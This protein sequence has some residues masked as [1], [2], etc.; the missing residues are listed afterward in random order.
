MQLEKENQDSNR[1]KGNQPEDTSKIK[2]G[3]FFRKIIQTENQKE[4]KRVKVL[5]QKKGI[6]PG[7]KGSGGWLLDFI[8]I[9]WNLISKVLN[10]VGPPIQKLIQ[11]TNDL[12]NKLPVDL[13]L[14]MVGLLLV[15]FGGFFSV[16]VA[17]L[18][19]IYCSGWE[20]IKVNF[21][22]LFAES[23]AIW[24]KSKEDDLK[25]EDNDGVADVKQMSITGLF[26]HK[27]GL[28]MANCK[29]PQKVIDMCHGI[30]QCNLNIIATL[31][32]DMAKA[33]TLGHSIGENL[34]KLMSIILVPA[35][36]YLLDKDYHHWIA[37][38]IN[39]VCK[40]ISI[41]ISMLIQRVLS[42]T[43]GAIRGG[44]LFSRRML[45]YL[46][47]IKVVNIDHESTYIDEYVGWGLASVGVLF[48]VFLGFS[49]PFPL[50][51]LL[52]PFTLVEEMLSTFF[53]IQWV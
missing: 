35:L 50:N 32:V 49:L 45:K 24:K 48:Q 7:Q 31:K 29:D 46:N 2:A 30:M 51:L 33:I 13:I 28:I 9:M 27:V 34:R 18:E 3:E 21:A 41:S 42:T 39:A 8:S 36:G 52:S 44:L 15:F 40:F 38:I 12:I 23:E 17:T 1:P 22:Y 47:S 11:A 20:T 14:S 4:D 25:D 16:T 43:Q 26:S 6:R 53:A 19:A 10:T 37:P 5:I